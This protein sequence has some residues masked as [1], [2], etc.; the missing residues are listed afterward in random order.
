MGGAFLA[1]GGFSAIGI[2]CLAAVIFSALVMRLAM[3]EPKTV[4]E[5]K[6]DAAQ[7]R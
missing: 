4:E 7:S 1:I 6:P 2:F 3:R 5:M